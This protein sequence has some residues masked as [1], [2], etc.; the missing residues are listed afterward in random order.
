LRLA[1]GSHFSPGPIR[2]PVDVYEGGIKVRQA[3]IV[4]QTF[5]AGGRFLYDADGRCYAPRLVGLGVEEIAVGE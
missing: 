2:F 1:D 3:V 4:R 5:D